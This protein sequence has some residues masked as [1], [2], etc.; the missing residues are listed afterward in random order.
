MDLRT[1][2]IAALAA[3]GTAG[4]ALAQD[5]DLAEGEK[6]YIAQCRVCHGDNSGGKLG[7]AAPLRFA[8]AGTGHGPSATL[9]AGATRTDAGELI[10]FAPPFGPNLR[11]IVGRLAGT[12]PEFEYS[13]AFLKALTGM[14]WSEGTLDWWIRDTQAWVPG[15]IMFYKQKDAEVRRKIILYLASNPN[16]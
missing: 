2:G 14:T 9:S 13:K 7:E 1:F 4:S 11:G 15:T 6:L 16:P 3:F 8:L 10:A 5:K 12:Y